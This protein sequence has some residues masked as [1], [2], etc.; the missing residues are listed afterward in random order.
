MSMPAERNPLRD[1]QEMDTFESVR[2]VIRIDSRSK[3]HPHQ[4]ERHG[5]KTGTDY[6]SYRYCRGDFWG[7]STMATTSMVKRL[8]NGFQVVD[9][10]VWDNRMEALAHD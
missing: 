3:I 4:L 5:L 6:V 9:R 2:E 7:S 10:E 1:P 8:K